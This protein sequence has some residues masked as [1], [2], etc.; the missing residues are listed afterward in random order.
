MA[1]D[2]TPADPAA[3]PAKKPRGANDVRLRRTLDG[4]AGPS[5]W[6]KGFTLRTFEPADAGEVHALLTRVFD[7]GADGPFDEWWARISGDAEFD[8]KLFFLVHDAAGRLVAVALAWTS[9]FVRDLAVDPG[10]RRLGLGEALMRHVFAVFQA[11][12]AAHVD[13]KTDLV[14]NADAA[15]LYRRLGMVE[16]DWD[17]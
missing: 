1:A 6:P 8:P 7:D 4:E 2:V 9:A 13:L 16:V 12:G 3:V 14:L 17:G 10:A 11:R 5:A 15:R